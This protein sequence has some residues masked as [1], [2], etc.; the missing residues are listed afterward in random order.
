[1]TNRAPS[2]ALV[3]LDS[4]L[5]LLAKAGLLSRAS[6]TTL[7]PPLLIADSDFEGHEGDGCQQATHTNRHAWK[8]S[9]GWLECSS[10]DEF[11]RYH[12]EDE[13]DDDCSSS[14][15]STWDEPASVFHANALIDNEDANSPRSKQS[16]VADK[17][18]SQATG[19]GPREST[20]GGQAGS[21]SAAAPA[22]AGTKRARAPSD[23]M[24]SDHDS[25]PS[26][27]RRVRTEDRPRVILACPFYK[28]NPARYR[29]CRRILLTKISYVKQHIL[30]SH[31]MPPHCQICNTL[32]QTDEQLRTHIYQ[33]RS[34][35][36]QKNSLEAQW[37]EVFDIIF[38]NAQR[39]AS[40][41]LD[42][43]LSQDLDEFVSYLTTN[44]PNIILEQIKFSDLLPRDNPQ[45][46][47]IDILRMNLSS[48]FQ[49]IYDRWYKNRATE[50]GSL[51]SS[52]P[53]PALSAPPE[54]HML[55]P[56][57]HPHPPIPGP[58]SL[59]LSHQTVFA[60][61]GSDELAP[62][63]ISRRSAH[64]GAQRGSPLVAQMP[65]PERS[66]HWPPQP[67]DR[68]AAAP[69]PQSPPPR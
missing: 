56:S 69:R 66:D 33:L 57:P 39:P 43:E 45:D 58:G 50:E 48:G 24:S 65:T 6:H 2:N 54:A 53:R 28:W 60:M 59:N 64:D 13:D 15:G 40:V 3:P 19:N 12:A 20:T 41:H 25:Q 14:G 67:S 26:R 29:G 68:S 30:R 9:G 34:R 23:I 37:Y 49:E 44:G 36:N 8:E 32:Y 55:R 42:P 62:L 16:V 11:E 22:R 27:S 63:R 1:M 46:I 38:P 51:P 31:R 7:R 21:G 52:L 18:A 10:D 61:G 47:N 17:N 5:E 4:T 35:V